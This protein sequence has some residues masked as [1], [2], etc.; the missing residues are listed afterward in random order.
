MVPLPG[1]SLASS[2]VWSRASFQATATL[3]KRHEALFGRAN[4]DYSR[5]NIDALFKKHTYLIF[6]SKTIHTDG[7]RAG[8]MVRPTRYI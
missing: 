5:S 8:V 4:T 7:I 1:N 3:S 2:K 6:P